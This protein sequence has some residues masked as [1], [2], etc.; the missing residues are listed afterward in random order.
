MSLVNINRL[1]SEDTQLI[2]ESN[3]LI[4]EKI[5]SFIRTKR[6]RLIKQRS[7]QTVS[8][9]NYHRAVSC[10][11]EEEQD[12]FIT[13]RE[14]Q[15]AENTTKLVEVDKL[16]A[17][18]PNESCPQN[19]IN[20]LDSNIK[21]KIQKSSSVKLTVNDKDEYKKKTII[22]KSKSN[23]INYTKMSNNKRTNTI[24]KR[25]SSK[26][27]VTRNLTY[28]IKSDETQMNRQ[29]VLSTLSVSSIE[30]DMDTPSYN[31][32]IAAATTCNSMAKPHSKICLSCVQQHFNNINQCCVYCNHSASNMKNSTNNTKSCSMP[33]QMSIESTINN[34]DSN[35]ESWVND[36]NLLSSTPMYPATQTKQNKNTSSN[37][38]SLLRSC[39]TIKSTAKKQ[40]S[41]KKEFKI[42]SREAC[43]I[44][45]RD[46]GQLKSIQTKQLKLKRGLKQTTK[47]Q[48]S[49]R[50]RKQVN[51]GRKYNLPRTS[52]FNSNSD[53]MEI[54]TGFEDFQCLSNN[55]NNIL[56]ESV[57]PP[58]CNQNFNN[59][60]DFVVWY[61]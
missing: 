16:N 36:T 40:Q 10:S 33:S 18:N 52:S 39:I 25:T 22:K 47:I 55:D 27:A 19:Q 49:K 14:S 3:S 7:E 60:G 54:G 45:T 46:P 13:Q 20:K 1:S 28:T 57:L 59:L 29:E 43:L 48:P 15:R 4:H 24:L 35:Y 26:K 2:V 32:H 17:R 56:F 38:F 58:K 44:A 8:N 51:S 53:D 21:K 42:E 50:P 30:C 11:R 12:F 31:H 5:V 41:I 6:A 23:N 61:V 37:P 9:R 34:I